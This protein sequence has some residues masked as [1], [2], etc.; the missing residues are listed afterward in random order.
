MN[1]EFKNDLQ[2]IIIADADCDF[3]LSEGI[4]D[5]FKARTAGAA[6]GVKQ[7]GTN[8]KNKA[9]GLAHGAI[10]GWK[11]EPAD[12]KMEEIHASSG[13]AIEKYEDVKLETWK[14]S[15]LKKFDKFTQI[16][17]KK[18]EELVD[19]AKK[20]GEDLGLDEEIL[21]LIDSKKLAIINASK[22]L[23]TN[24]QRIFMN[25]DEVRKAN[26]ERDRERKAARSKKEA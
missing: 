1:K 20:D 23:S 22:S 17:I 5:K 15:M 6:A 2:D 3:M 19:E 4:W 14:N 26:L 7:M 25:K 9:K 24:M 12:E 18:V 10:S 11:N 8:I 13:D 16:V 21:D